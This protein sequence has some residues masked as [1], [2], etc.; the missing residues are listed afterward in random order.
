MRCLRKLSINLV[1]F[2]SWPHKHDPLIQQ[3]RIQDLKEAFK[4]FRNSTIKKELQML[5]SL[6][7]FSSNG[8]YKKISR[9]KVDKP[10]KHLDLQQE[11]R[12]IQY[13]SRAIRERELILRE[14][15]DS[16][17]A[18]FMHHIH[19]L[20][21][22]AK[23]KQEFF[24]IKS[25]Q[26]ERELIFVSDGNERVCSIVSQGQDI[27]KNEELSSITSCYESVKEY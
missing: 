8:S 17:Q 12:R 19:S 18:S 26:P 22:P 20:S 21:A 6:F 4:I 9:R 2:M 25:E 7:R 15:I 23:I 5:I 27:S 3:Q 13:K 1:N 10:Q 16:C 24:N 11:A 14:E